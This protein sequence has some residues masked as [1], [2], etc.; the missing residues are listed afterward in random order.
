MLNPNPSPVVFRCFSDNT[1]A[2]LGELHRSPGCRGGCRSTRYNFTLRGDYHHSDKTSIFGRYIRYNLAE[3]LGAIAYSPY[4]N[5]D[6]GATQKDY[7]ALA[8]LTHSF[9]TSLVTNARVAFSRINL[10][11][12]STPIAV[13]TPNLFLGA[14][15]N[16]GGVAVALPG[17]GF[18]LPYG[19]PQ[20]V[21]Q[22]NQDVNWSKKAHSFQF[23]SQVL[24]IQENRTFGAFAQATEQLAG[25][26]T[27]D[28]TGYPGLFSGILGT[29]STAINPERAYPGQEI[30]TPATQ[31]NFARSDRFHDWAV[32]GQDGWRATSKLTV[33]YGVRYEY[34]GVQHNNRQNLDSNFYWGSGNGLPQQ[35]RTGA[36]YTALTESD[37][38]VVEAELW[39]GESAGRVCL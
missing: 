36:V 4:S 16:I 14:N 32:Y 15:A 22:W 1:G 33:N 18:P 7:S 34:F 29:F 39:R 37:P 6:I 35:V 25:S 10:N 8:G 17:T 20:N 30:T 3:P 31:P 28:T 2:G 19:G 26:V 13:T 9:S 5:Y 24:Y 11:N 21:I 27:G 38:R 23:G 12:D